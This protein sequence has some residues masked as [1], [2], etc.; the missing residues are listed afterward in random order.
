MSAYKILLVEDE[1]IAALALEESLKELGYQV[2][3][4]ASSRAEALSSISVALPDLVLMDINLQEKEEGIAA[5]ETIMKEYDIPVVFL[6]AYADKETISKAKEVFPYGYMV[7]PYVEL[8]LL[9]VIETA[10][11]K[12]QADK[13]QR[14]LHLL[15]TKFYSIIAHDLRS[16]LSAL[17]FTTRLLKR[18]FDDLSQDQLKDFIAE[19]HDTVKNINHFTENL[20]DWSKSQSGKT[21]LYPEEILMYDLLEEVIILLKGKALN[22][23][24]SIINGV[25]QEKV[26]ADKN[27]LHSVLLNLLQNG[28]KYCHRGGTVKVQAKKENGVVHIEV[29]DDGV[30][31]EEKQCLHLFDFKTSR[32]TLGTQE[33]KGTGLGL[34]LCK[35]FV[36][37]NRGTIMVNSEKGKGTRVKISLP[38]AAE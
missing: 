31:M 30:G 6:T 32:H 1:S 28:L 8:E 29:Q 36:E 21:P 22:K 24:V 5:G 38:A 4:I 18:K 2:T 11:H 16:P 7:K 19:I 35:E 14:E 27:M 15:K 13:K 25:G 17:E 26:I 33:E 20:L 12:H 34:L 3:G 9:A 10:V 37:A 23:Q